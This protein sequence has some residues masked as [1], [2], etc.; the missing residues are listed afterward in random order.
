MR[1][2]SLLLFLSL[3]VVQQSPLAYEL[4]DLGDSSAA[5]FTPQDEAMLGREVMTDIRSSSEYFDDPETVDF[6][7]SVG[8]RLLAVS[9]D[10]ADIKFE[11]FVVQDPT[12]NAFALPGGYIGVHTGLITA[13]ESESELASVLA[14]EIS[15]VTQHHIARMI[16]AQSNNLPFAFAAM[17]A[18]I[19]AAR[20]NP[21][22]AAG[23]VLGSQA[24]MIQAQLDFTR[25]NEREAD[26]LGINRMIK[27]PYDPHAMATFFEKLQ[28]YGRFYEGASPAYLKTHPLTLQRLSE[29]EDRIHAI[30]PR[31]VV[32]RPD[33][34]L[35]QERINALTGS[36]QD[37]L[38]LFRERNPDPLIVADQPVVYGLAV[39]QWRSHQL[40]QANQ[41]LKSLQTRVAPNALY[42]SLEAQILHDGNHYDEALKVYRQALKENP[43]TRSLKYGYVATLIDAGQ[44]RE[45][46][47]FLQSNLIRNYLDYRLNNFQ[48]RAYANLNQ[49]ML[50]HWALAES[51]S[52]QGNLSAS[53]DQLMIAQRS[54]DGDFYQKSQVEA[55]IRE[56]K[57]LLGAAKKGRGQGGGGPSRLH[58][59]DLS[60]SN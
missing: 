17:A 46:L 52:K 23:A 4:P 36:P 6:V 53:L 11:F 51:Y 50:S 22:M 3:F 9:D 45:A 14:H 15:H 28:R 31:H 21:D 2:V 5:T 19:L 18:A 55:R 48:A 47:D 33:F 59:Q 16:E 7:S 37:A 35:I 40:D 60:R 26:R 30:A 25:E 49:Q 10:V 13:A 29:I 43:N 56:I 54:G 12:L 34:R 41:T 8:Y 57:T 1:K 27:S 39:A 42:A 32:D 58:S 20:S 44:N 24:G 38:R